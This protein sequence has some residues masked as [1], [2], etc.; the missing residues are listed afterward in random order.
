MS[1]SIRTIAQQTGMSASTV[2]LALRGVG[3]ISAETRR[4]IQ[5]VAKSLGY[6]THPLLAKALSLA[7]SPEALSYRESLAFIVE[8][9]TE[10]GPNYQR[11]IHA[12]AQERA[13]SLGYKL[14]S[15]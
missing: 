6:E 13:A 3:R 5:L 7:R 12:A 10:K 8:Y 4:K 11:Q 9:P 1:T 14:E 2:S 15:F